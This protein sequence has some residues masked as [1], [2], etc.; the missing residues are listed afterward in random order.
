MDEVIAKQLQLKLKI[1]RSSPLTG[2]YGFSSDLN[3]SV[4]SLNATT[5][6]GS[7]P[8]PDS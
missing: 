7:V 6:L 3:L 8:L 5:A 4:L 2:L 1:F